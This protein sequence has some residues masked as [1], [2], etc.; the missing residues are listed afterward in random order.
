LKLVQLALSESAEIV[1]S[2]TIPA[3]TYF[4]SAKTIAAGSEATTSVF[5]AVICQLVDS[6]GTPHFG[7]VEE[8][9]DTS[10]WAQQLSEAGGGHF[11]GAATM[12]LQGQLT[13]TEPTTLALVCI[14]IEGTKGATVDV[15]DSQ[16]SAL[17]TTANK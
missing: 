13:T 16:V 4:T 11:A 2:K 12:E 10:E 14:P 9:I 8:A 17:Q 15:L 6:A 3:G 7:E 1:V 5:V